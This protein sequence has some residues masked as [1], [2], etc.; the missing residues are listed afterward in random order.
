MI[1]GGTCLRLPFTQIRILT[2]QKTASTSELLTPMPS[3]PLVFSNHN[4]RSLNGE[5]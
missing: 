5:R 4:R 3:F 1:F 2:Y